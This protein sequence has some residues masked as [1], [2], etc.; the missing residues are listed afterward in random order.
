MTKT[1]AALGCVLVPSALLSAEAPDPLRAKAHELQRRIVVL[2]THA[3]MTALFQKDTKVP[4]ITDPDMAGAG[5][6]PSKD[7]SKVPAVE[8]WMKEFP[9]TWSFGARHDKGILDL[10][11]MREG[12]LNAEFVSIFM[13]REPRP[14]MAIKRSLDYIESVYALVRKYPKDIALA[15]TA[16]DVRDNVKAGLI[17]FLIGMEGGH[18]IE[19]DLRVLRLYQKLG[20]RYLTLTHCFNTNW[21]DSSGCGTPVI[22]QHNGLSL[23]GKEVVMELNRLGIMV[24]IT[25]TA[26]KTFYD[27][28]AISKAPVIA[29][30]SSVD[31]IKEHARNMSDDM[32]RALAKNGGVIQINCVVKYIDPLEG[33]ET[34]ISVFIDHVAHAIKVAGPDHVGIGLDFSYTAPQPQ[35]L[36]NVKD[37]EN[38]TYE[39]LKRGFDEATV[40]KVWGENTLRVMAEVE[41]VAARLQSAR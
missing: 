25:H 28:V 35:G 9:E 26:D 39:L 18:M 27:A 17:S 32:L 20:V 10:P 4:E 16:Q 33:R 37:M 15:T 5:Y 14:G 22:P 38:I 1:L 23:F 36:K 40:R 12:G 13:E 29:S 11:R 41:R 21:A 34:P 19:D 24:D 3:D 8:N 2:D 6:D 30:H 31:G 7:A